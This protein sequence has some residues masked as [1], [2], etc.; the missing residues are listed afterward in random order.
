MLKVLLLA[1][2]VVSVDAKSK[3][4]RG[5]FAARLVLHTHIRMPH[6]TGKAEHRQSTYE[7]KGQ[8]HFLKRTKMEG[9]ERCSKRRVRSTLCEKPSCGS[10]VL[11]VC[12]LEVSAHAAHGHTFSC[13]DLTRLY[14][15]NFFT[16]FQRATR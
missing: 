15:P 4:F 2:A 10:P 3:G 8:P 13:I 7:K 11:A 12:K 16:L 5:P 9:T 1:V 14:P 6:T